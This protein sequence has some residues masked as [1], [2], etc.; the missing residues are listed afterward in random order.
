MAPSSAL[1]IGGQR[2]ISE[3]QAI[4]VDPALSGS[5]LLNAVL[6]LLAPFDAG[7]DENGHFADHDI[8]GYLIVYVYGTSR[9]VPNPYMHAARRSIFRRGR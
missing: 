9:C 1:P 2:R 4:P 8:A 3:V 6:A 7:H 5:G